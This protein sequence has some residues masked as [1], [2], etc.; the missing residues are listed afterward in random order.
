MLDGDDLMKEVEPW[1]VQEGTG[2]SLTHGSNAKPFPPL[3]D[4]VSSGF[5]AAK[6]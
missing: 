3:M 4:G 6:R 5:L 1:L 2:I